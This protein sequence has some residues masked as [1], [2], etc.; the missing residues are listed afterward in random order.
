MDR[1]YDKG[2]DAPGYHGRMYESGGILMAEVL[3]VEG[4][5]YALEFAALLLDLWSASGSPIETMICNHLAMLAYREGWIIKGQQQIEEYRVD[6]LIT[7]PFMAA[8]G[9]V[10]ECDGHDF[11]ERTKEQAAR[12]RKRDRRLQQLGYV[13]LRFTGSEIV[14]ALPTVLRE[15]ES[16]VRPLAGDPL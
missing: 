5:E 3:W 7:Y 4:K 2:R 11:H 1:T 13:V 14:S 8:S 9:V 10:V 15:I 16:T 12:D 6:F